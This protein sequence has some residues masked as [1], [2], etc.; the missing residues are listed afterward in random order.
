MAAGFLGGS[1]AHAGEL[2]KFVKTRAAARNVE[3]GKRISL[4]DRLFK[5]RL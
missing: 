1:L 3:I 4:E 2:V 5:G